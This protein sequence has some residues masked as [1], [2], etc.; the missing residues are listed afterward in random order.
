LIN[1]ILENQPFLLNQASISGL[2]EPLLINFTYSKHMQQEGELTLSLGPPDSLNTLKQHNWIA[3]LTFVIRYNA[4][5]W[6]MLIGGV[7]GGRTTEARQ[8]AKRA[9]HVFHGL[10]PK[11]LLVYLLREVAAAWGIGKIYAISDTA[12]C[13]MRRRYQ[14]RMR[15]MKSSY[16]EL[17]RDVG[18]QLA[19]NGFYALP[20]ANRRRPVDT[21]PSRKRAQY[22]RRF[23]LL[24]S[25]NGEIH[26]KLAVKHDL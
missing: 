5:E 22:L 21:I 15:S 13:Y 16:D 6:E 11:H 23:A 2:R 10:R 24:D 4:A 18:G 14:D 9:T 8:D 3:S 7:Q 17:W 1:A 26:D 12:H 19:A 20:A 25:I